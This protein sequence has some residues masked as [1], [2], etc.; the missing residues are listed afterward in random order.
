MEGYRVECRRGRGARVWLSGYHAAQK[1]WQRNDSGK[2]SRLDGGVDGSG[3]ACVDGLQV[4]GS[5]RGSTVGRL[6]HVSTQTSSGRTSSRVS[7]GRVVVG[8]DEEGHS[9]GERVSHVS[10]ST[11]AAVSASGAG[12]H[13]SQS[14]NERDGRTLEWVETI[15]ESVASNESNE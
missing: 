8:N 14:G 15:N 4:S 1:R 5:G 9:A 3:V 13:G 7:D 12:R 10:G 11:Q 6:R 2:T